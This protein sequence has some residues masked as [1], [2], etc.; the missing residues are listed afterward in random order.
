LLL[1]IEYND[2]AIGLIG[3]RNMK[4]IV[5]LALALTFGLGTAVFAADTAATGTE[6]AASTAA[7]PAPKKATKH[8]AH[9]GARRHKAAA[10]AASTTAAPKTEAK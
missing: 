1:N 10:P 5:S 2:E 4:N 6:P 9:H 8:H 7:A 3:V